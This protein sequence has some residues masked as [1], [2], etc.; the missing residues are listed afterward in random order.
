MRQRSRRRTASG[1]SLADGAGLSLAPHPPTSACLRARL[2]AHA[3]AGFPRRRLRG[4][5][6][7]QGRSRLG[8]AARARRRR[9]CK[10]PQRV[11]HRLFHGT[12]RR[13]RFDRT[14]HQVAER[15]RF[16]WQALHFA[17]AAGID[18]CPNVCHRPC[19]RA[20]TI[21]KTQP[22]SRCRRHARC[23]PRAPDTPPAALNPTP[24]AM[25]DGLL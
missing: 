23:T 17:S 8:A 15:T 9:G 21:G 11:F 14:F 18:T 24:S 16:S 10:P 13:R 4:A 19:V 5:D 1:E 6:G 25:P 20:C 2:H 22:S 3:H 12:L 7:M